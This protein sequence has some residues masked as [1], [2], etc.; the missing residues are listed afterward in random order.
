MDLFFVLS[1]FLIGGILLDERKAT[2]YF[3]VFYVR[4]VCRILPA[5][6]AILGLTAIGYYFLYPLH[7]LQLKTVYANPIPWYA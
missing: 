6:F 2:N 1:G 3:K 5:Y 7:P 4:R